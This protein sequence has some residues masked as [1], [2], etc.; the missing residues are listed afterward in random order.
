MRLLSQM[1]VRWVLLW[2]LC[3]IHLRAD[4][5]VLPDKFLRVSIPPNSPAIIAVDY[6]PDLIHWSEHSTNRVTDGA[7]LISSTNAPTGD[8]R[9]YRLAD[10]RR[11][12]LLHGVVQAYVQTPPFAVDRCLSCEGP[13]NPFVTAP[14]TPIGAWAGAA[15][16]VSSTGES[17]IANVAGE[18]QFNRRFDRSELPLTL[19]TSI[20]GF[21]NSV[22]VVTADSAGTSIATTPTPVMTTTGFGSV[23]GPARFRFHFN[24]GP[25]RGKDFIATTDNAGIVFEGAL[26]MIGRFNPWIGMDRTGLSYYLKPTMEEGQTISLWGNEMSGQ[27]FSM[28][29]PGSSELVNGTFSDEPL[30]TVSPAKALDSMEMIFMHPTHAAMTVI[31]DGESGGEFSCI[32]AETGRGTYTYDYGDSVGLLTLQFRDEP[33]TN[34]DL[35]I[36]T[37]E[38]ESGVTTN[39][40]T[41]FVFHSEG[42]TTTMGSGFF[43]YAR[44][45]TIPPP[46]AIA[47]PKTLT[48]PDLTVLDGTAPQWGLRVWLSGTDVG[49]FEDSEHSTGRF[50]YKPT[51]TNATLRLD[52]PNATWLDLKLDFY[53]PS[54]SWQT[55]HFTGT[56]MSGGLWSIEGEFYYVGP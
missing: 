52:Y 51:A 37:F 17:A 33:S 25:A 27:I 47:P 4:V 40:S 11:T 14:P 39:N 7:I 32:G 45:H 44:R 16:S 26:N 53:Y 18:F 56:V 48:Y 9:F 2:T 31:F 15:V 6:S 20:K 24:T 12:F 41:F 50:D 54:E 28:E 21:S 10:A 35:F 13:S 23:F 55:N 49:T 29:F 36:L 19:I 43:T 3:A 22:D 42:E 34:S 5:T 1:A 46:P 38:S 8:V 30:P